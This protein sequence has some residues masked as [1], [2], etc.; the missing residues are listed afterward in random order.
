MVKEAANELKDLPSLVQKPV[1]HSIQ[2]R[3]YAEDCLQNFRPSA[4]QL[5]QVLLSKK[6]RVE[7][8][9]RDG[10]TVTSLYDP[11][12]AKIIVHGDNREDAINKLHQALEETRFYGVT[13]NLQYL[14]ALLLDE[15]CKAGCV[16]TQ[17]LNGFEPAEN[18]IE[19]LDGGV[20]T[21]VQDFPK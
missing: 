6:A 5:D 14:Q 21:T 12:L 11:M 9:L 3:I 2:A 7:T 15:E 13:T 1:G 20:Q 18:A 16:Y 4:G 8:W 10:V 17:M 19:V